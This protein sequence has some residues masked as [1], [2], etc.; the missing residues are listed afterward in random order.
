MHIVDPEFLCILTWVAANIVSIWW[1]DREV[2][3]V[4]A[5][6]SA[7]WWVYFLLLLPGVQAWQREFSADVLPHVA[8]FRRRLQVWCFGV[9][10]L[11]MLV[12]IAY[13][14]LTG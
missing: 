14:N 4:R 13:V 11:P 1:V 9:L 7:S 2:E 12:F 10:W 6:R 8:K 3:G 5:V